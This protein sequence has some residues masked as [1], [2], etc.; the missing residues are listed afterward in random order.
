MLKISVFKQKYGKKFGYYK[1][2]FYFFYFL[3]QVGEWNVKIQIILFLKPYSGLSGQP[4]SPT[5][6]IIFPLSTSTNI[7][8]G[9]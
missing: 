6:P 9:L 8:V 7:G 4:A 2:F 5:P 1:S 3:C